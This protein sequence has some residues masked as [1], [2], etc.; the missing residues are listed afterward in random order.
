MAYAT[1]RNKTP[2]LRTRT[3]FNFIKTIGANITGGI[4]KDNLSILKQIFDSGITL[5]HT[6]DIFNYN[7]LNNER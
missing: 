7:V 2:N 5:W 3:H 4:P 6:N 1:N